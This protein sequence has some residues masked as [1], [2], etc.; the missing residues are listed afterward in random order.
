MPEPKRENK[1]NGS[2]TQK[3]ILIIVAFGIPSG[4]S[5]VWWA[6]R[7][8]AKTEVRQEQ[9]ARD[10]RDTEKEIDGLLEVSQEQSKSITELKTI[11]KQHLEGHHR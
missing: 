7:A 4:L 5:A 3:I 1:L 8:S 9:L 2:L 11:Q 6:G 10:V